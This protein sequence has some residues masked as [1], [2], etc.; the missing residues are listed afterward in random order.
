MPKTLK[1]KVMA[2]CVQVIRDE[3]TADL[4]GV[5]LKDLGGRI[6][7]TQIRCGRHLSLFPHTATE[8][9][10]LRFP[11]GESVVINPGDKVM[12][13]HINWPKRKGKDPLQFIMDV[14]EEVYTSEFVSLAKTLKGCGGDIKII[15]GTSPTV[16][17]GV[18]RLGFGVVDSTLL[19]NIGA[20]I[21]YSIDSMRVDPREGMKRVR[22]NLSKPAL[23][24]FIT[25]K[26]VIERFEDEEKARK[27]WEEYKH[28]KNEKY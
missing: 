20:T 12:N 25:P 6:I 18:T 24:A 28:P 2:A 5:F 21:G 14:Q 23:T 26:R 4:D 7:P 16:N 27:T 1:E 10:E 17:K 8:R 22:K 13:M 19:A 9:R 15:L 3:S 11:D